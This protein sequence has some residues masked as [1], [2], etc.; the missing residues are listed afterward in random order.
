MR[1]RASYRLCIRT[2]HDLDQRRSL[3]SGVLKR[4]TTQQPSTP[5]NM[6][7]GELPSAPERACLSSWRDPPNAIWRW[8]ATSARSYQWHG[9]SAMT[10]E[11][12]SWWVVTDLDGTLLDHHYDWSPATEAIRWLQEQGIPV[13][14]ALARRRGGASLPT[15]C[16]SVRSVHR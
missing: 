11:R 5:H 3:R 7:A 10:Q 15:G 13:F 12:S 2:L 14:P 6:T 4:G 16:L 8:S 1:L 9:S